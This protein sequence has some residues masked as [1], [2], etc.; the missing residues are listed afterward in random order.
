MISEEAGGPRGLG[1]REDLTDMEL[2][3]RLRQRIADLSVL[4]NAVV[5]QVST[6]LPLARDEWSAA[7]GVA[8]GT[9]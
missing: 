5:G 7:F 4:P 3:Y 6:L 9:F 8:D 1:P 2:L